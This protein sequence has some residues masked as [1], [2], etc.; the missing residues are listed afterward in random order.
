LPELSVVVP[1]WNTRELLRRC[2]QTLYAAELPETEVF[3]IDNGSADGSADMVA[4]EFP[5]VN[6]VR[7]EC[8]EGFAI[9]C[10]QGMRRSVG[11]HVLL[12]NADTEVQPDAVRLLLSWLEEHP[13]YG[14]TPLE[15]WLP[16]SREL[17]RYF[18]R[19][20][21]HED[22]RDVDQP[23]AACLLVRRE[24]LDQVGLFDE[25]L[26]LFYN[27]VDLSRR[28]QAA[29]WRT[30]Y[31]HEAR[32][33]HHI[34]ASTG[35][36]EG[37]VTMWQAN[38]LSYYRKHHGRLAGAWLK[39]CVTLSWVDFMVQQLWKRMRGRVSEPLGPWT[40]NYWEYLRS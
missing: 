34:G 24:V 32:V 18:L 6:L 14:A 22:S 2:L 5:Q 8:N 1:S 25:Q 23:P 19:A 10:N 39:G 21:N 38:R 20:W 30:R 12:L 35:Q 28:M 33:L 37:F 11:R 26:W 29:G 31:I 9:G 40:R 3:V 16:N 36:F 17:R 13:E 15:R 7:N 27:D 4:L